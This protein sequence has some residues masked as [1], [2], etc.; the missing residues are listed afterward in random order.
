MTR[1]H[2]QLPALLTGETCAAASTRQS[3]HGRG[4]FGTITQTYDQRQVQLG[5]KM[6]F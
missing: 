5:L 3:Q 2:A 1:I 6:N 4:A